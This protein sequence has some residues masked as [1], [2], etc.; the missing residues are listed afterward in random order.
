MKSEADFWYKLILKNAAA[1]SELLSSFLFDCGAEGLQEQDDDL[2]AFFSG[3]QNLGK[4]QKVVKVYL[5]KLRQQNF[6]PAVFEIEAE[7]VRRENWQQNWMQYFKPVVIDDRLIVTPS[8]E[9]VQPEEGKIILTI[10]P[11]QAFGTGGHA[12]TYLMLQLLLTSCKPEMQIL[13]VGTGSGILAVAAA[14]L[15]CEKIVAFDTDPVAVETA[16]RN[17]KINGVSEKIHFFT[18]EITSLNPKKNRFDFIL[19][20]IS[21]GVLRHLLPRFSLFMKNPNF[22]VALSGILKEEENSL[23][24]MLRD[25]QFTVLKLIEKEEW[26]CYLCG[27]V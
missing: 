3:R 7:L 11:E 26:A 14:K 12:T 23:A 17:A 19:A 20:N 16:K 8:W 21:S 24:K 18:G 22:L 10:D 6:L 5:E 27:K 1:Y 25:F 9:K 2:F 13:D 4:L 15:G